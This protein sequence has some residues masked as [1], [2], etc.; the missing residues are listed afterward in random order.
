MPTGEKRS[1]PGNG[2][3]GRLWDGKVM[4]R[5]LAALVSL[6]FALAFAGPSLAQEETTSAQDAGGDAPVE[7]VPGE[8]LA[9]PEIEAGAWALADLGSGR[10]LGAEGQDERLPIGSTTKIMSALVVLEAA[11]NGDVSLEDEVVISPQAE[12]FV[13][14]VYSN[15]GLIAGE[16]VT[17][18]ELL[19]ASLIPSGTEAVYALAEHVGG[20][21]GDAS[22]ERF[23]GLMNDKAEEMGLRNTRF[24]SPAGLDSPDNY[25]SARDM[26]EISREA[27]AYPEFRELVAQPEATISTDSREIEVFNTNA[28][29]N[30]YPPATGIKTG[31]TDEGGPSLVASAEEGGESYV[32]IVLDA[33]SAD[34]TEGDRFADS[35]AVLDYGFANNETQTLANEGD[36]YGE[37]DVP[38]RRGETVELAAAEDVEALVAPGTEF[39]RRVTTAEL[40]RSA[41]TGDR[42]GEVEI[43]VDGLSVGQSPLLATN[44]YE[45]A[46]FFQKTWYRVS[47]LWN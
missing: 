18:R 13:G 44:G 19:E 46:S 43:F 33:V 23:V 37:A 5:A 47:S 15:V 38:F 31:T 2:R 3:T 7:T 36:V 35:Q 22:V 1:S 27:M 24:D 4:A 14:S 16:S 30:S 25:S 34:G 9:P 28:L 10:L 21:G 40:P 32:S 26:A 39:E 11:E 12:E 8:A 17:V 29:L 41:Q 6:A 42:L 45:E 20:G